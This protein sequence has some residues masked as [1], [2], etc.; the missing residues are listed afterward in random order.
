MEGGVDGAVGSCCCEWTGVGACGW[1]VRGDGRGVDVDYLDI[2]VVE[3]D[4]FGVFGDIF[5][6]DELAGVS[7]SSFT[8]AKCLLMVMWIIRLLYRRAVRIRRL[9]GDT[10]FKSRGEIEAENMKISEV[11]KMTLV[12]P[13]VLCFTEPIVL[14]WNIYIAL[15]YGKFL[16]L[17]I[18]LRTYRLPDDR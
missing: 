15:V 7:G 1:W 2:D 14:F 6:G 17:A 4:E 9:T 12:R 13:F 18:I 10:R 3:W 11:A 16:C 8:H 5:A